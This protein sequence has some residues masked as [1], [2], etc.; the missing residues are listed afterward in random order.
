MRRS[1]ENTPLP[2][3]IPKEAIKRYNKKY[4]QS[5]KG[6][7]AHERWHK[8]DK[9]K[10]ILF[11]RL[12]QRQVRKRVIEHYGGIPPSCACCGEGRY[13]FLSLNHLGPRGSGNID[14]KKYRGSQAGVLRFI[15]KN[16]FPEGYNVLCYNCNLSRGFLGYCPHE[17]ER[18]Q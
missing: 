2:P 18:A 4:F 10:I 11:N 5:D 17:K 6:K 3:K 16:N 1:P 7:R 9:D 14:R 12:Y 13:E 15:V 8:K